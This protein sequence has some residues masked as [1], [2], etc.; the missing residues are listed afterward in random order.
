MKTY[1]AKIWRVLAIGTP[2]RAIDIN[3]CAIKPDRL[4]NGF[5][6][7]STKFRNV[8]QK[9]HTDTRR[10]LLENQSN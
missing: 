3:N 5:T 6:N 8:P 10:A 9:C 2:E 7:V 1:A 4:R